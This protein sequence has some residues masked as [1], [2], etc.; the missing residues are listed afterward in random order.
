M[1]NRVKAAVVTMVKLNKVS[2]Y[3]LALYLLIA[4]SAFACEIIMA[5]SNRF[6]P[7]HMKNA[8]GSWG[9][10]SVDIASALVKKAN[11]NLSV[12]SIPW[13]RS[14]ALLRLGEVHLMSNFTRDDE[15][16]EFAE[17]LGPHHIEKVAFL[18]RSEQNPSIQG[19]SH[20]KHFNGVIAITRGTSFGQEFDQFIKNEP[21]M[22]KKFIQIRSNIDRYALLSRGRIEAMFIDEQSAQYFLVKLHSD[23]HINNEF[24][25]RFTLRG[26]PVYFGISPIGVSATLRAK[27]NQSWRELLAEDAV[28]KVYKKYGL[29]INKDELNN[30]DKQWLTTDH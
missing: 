25:I 29:T 17:F 9:G 16:S 12:I 4:Q 7:Y 28:I 1:I 22:Y 23:K 24:G 10:V 15:R 5:V 18:A 6:P 13:S 19:L 14:V 3:C 11:C 8:D 20:L 30:H 21:L 26:N 27:L 2:G